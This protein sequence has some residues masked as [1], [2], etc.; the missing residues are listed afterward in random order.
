[1]S[2]VVILKGSPKKGGNTDILAD[3]FADAARTAGHEIVDIPVGRMHLEGCLGCRACFKT[4][5]PCVIDKDG[6]NAIVDDLL[7]ADA[8]V[9]ALPVY[10]FGWPAQVKA[11]LDRMFCLGSSPDKGVPHKKCFLLSAAADPTEIG[12]FDAPIMVFT[13]S[14]E[15][16]GWEATGNVCAG[17][18]R[19]HGAVLDTDFPAQ[20]AALAALL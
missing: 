5:K 11:A 3:A 18:C 2:K 15:L 4:G 10:W 20:A 7:A 16:V 8:I 13:K 19:E 17:S 12:V 9:F 1:M 14:V 6:W